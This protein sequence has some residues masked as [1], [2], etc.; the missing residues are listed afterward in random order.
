MRFKYNKYFS[1]FNYFVLFAINSLFITSCGNSVEKEKHQTNFPKAINEEE[2]KNQFVK[3]N[4][5]L[6]Q[7]ESDEMDYYVKTHKMPFV[8]TSSGIRYYV[9]K[10]SAHGDSIKDR[11]EIVMNFVVSFSYFHHT[12][13]S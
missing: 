13:K 5:Q 6:V 8:K 10:P 12:Y 11:E 1:I 4:K 7:K 2:L 9:Y 3:A